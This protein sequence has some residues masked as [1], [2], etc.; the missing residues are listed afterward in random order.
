MARRRQ[1]E[2]VSSPRSDEENP[3]AEADTPTAAAETTAD[4]AD[5]AS[6]KFTGAGFRTGVIA[7]VP[8]ALGVAGYGL[9]FGVVAARAGLSVAEA[10]LMSATVLA[11]AAQ[12]VA[13]EL[14]ADP[15][16][17]VALLTTTA[18]INLRYV[19]LGAALHP[20][21][22]SLSP[23]TAY[24]SVFF[25]ADENWALSIDAFRNGRR[26]AAFLLGSGVVLWLLW[27]LATVVG[28]TAGDL[29]GDPARLGLDFVVTALFL[30]LAV[31]FWEGRQSLLPWISA[32]AVGIAADAVLPGEW[33]IL[34][35]ALVGAAAAV[36]RRDD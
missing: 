2:P 34:C 28:A 20:W 26:D 29:I 10:A 8:V 13:V 6:M 1:V 14:W 21:L 12:L 18:V 33:Y 32:A 31:G 27:V 36:V 19:L 35:G 17:V 16:P 4:D 25:V 7:G 9:V 3:A 15:I 30:T 11:G 22:R 5:T 24:T 23:L